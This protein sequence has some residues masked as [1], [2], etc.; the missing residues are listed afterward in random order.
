MHLFLE[1]HYKIKY[2]TGICCGAMDSYINAHEEQLLSWSRILDLIQIMS[3]LLPI[4]KNTELSETK[5][6]NLHLLKNNPQTL[7]LINTDILFSMS[8]GTNTN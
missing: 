4:P 5:K 3:S 1:A 8:S 2:H 6:V 7:L